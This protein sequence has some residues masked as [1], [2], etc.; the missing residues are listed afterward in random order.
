MFPRVYGEGEADFIP[1]KQGLYAFFLDLISPAKIGLAGRGPFSEDTLCRA[2]ASLLARVE[3]H[4]NVLS[5][6]PLEGLIRDGLRQQHLQ[7]TYLITATRHNQYDFRSDICGLPLEQIRPYSELLRST[8]A[9]AQPIYVGLT[10]D[11]TLHVRYRQHMADHD[12]GA[13][14]N[15]FGGRLKRLG[16]AWDDV[17]FTCLPTESESLT[18]QLLA[19]AERYLHATAMPLLS[20]G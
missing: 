13:S 18:R 20:V 3:R 16:I 2:R 6:I 9:Y 19:T 15:T 7:A 8:V 4:F 11:Q 10:F 12:A 14:K 1:K 17:T 5:A